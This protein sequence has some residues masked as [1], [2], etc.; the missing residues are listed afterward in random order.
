MISFLKITET[1][2]SSGLPKLHETRIIIYQ[3]S[4]L[5]N[6]FLRF[7]S[8]HTGCVPVLRGI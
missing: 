2:S 5:D 8:L 4:S 6:F 7:R 3:S 1:S